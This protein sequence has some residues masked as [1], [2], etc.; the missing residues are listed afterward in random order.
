MQ[1]EPGARFEMHQILNHPFLK[2]KYD[3]EFGIKTKKKS[4]KQTELQAIAEE[5][6]V[7]VY[8]ISNFL[9]GLYLC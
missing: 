2:K 6:E 8:P 3:K 4:K 1:A 5:Q 7:W 9:S